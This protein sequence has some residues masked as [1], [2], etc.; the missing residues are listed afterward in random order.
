MSN[1]E[2]FK[3]KKRTKGVAYL[4][5]PFGT[6]YCRLEDLETRLSKDLS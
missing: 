2:L 5:N 1:V 6:E 4:S 3:E